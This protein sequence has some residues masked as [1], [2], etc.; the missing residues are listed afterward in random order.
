MICFRFFRTK[1]T[2][3]FIGE[4]SFDAFLVELDKDVDVPALVSYEKLLLFKNNA[5]NSDIR[6][7]E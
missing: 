6:Y 7:M 5:N 1:K 3:S 4:L 2:F